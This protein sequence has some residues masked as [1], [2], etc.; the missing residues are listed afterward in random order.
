VGGGPAGLCFALVAK[1]RDPGHKVTVFERNEA[2]STYGWGVTF[3]RDL[4]DKLYAC[5]PVS[6]GEIERA[7]FRWA[8]Q[9]VDIQDEQV[10]RADGEGYSIKRQRLLGIMADRAAGLGVRIEFGHEVMAPPQLPAA[11]LIVACDGANSRTRLAARR[12]PTD[13]HISSNKYVW[14]GTDKVF[15]SF[16]YTF[17]RTDSGWVWAYGYGVDA[18]SSTFIV[19][20]SPE[21]WAGLGLDVMPPDESLRLLEKLFARQLGGHQLAGQIGDNTD[22]RWLNFHTI[23]NRHWHDGKVVLAG[24]AAHT[25]HYSIG[26]GTKLAIE[27]VIA[28]AE[29]LEEH[30]TLEGALSSYEAQRRAALLPPQGEARCSARWFENISRYVD[31]EPHQ[32]S[33][34]LDGRRSPLLPHIPPRLYY[35]LLR[36]S[37]NITILRELRKRAAPR[38]KAIYS[39]RGPDRITGLSPTSKIRH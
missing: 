23:T 24:D 12:F 31:L 22:V 3:G 35:R 15:D 29:N 4:L 30:D 2:D 39:R 17:V 14:L 25:T 34:L 26:W 38:A 28:L 8:G 18:A 32:F 10:R 1:L 27:D 6:A 13:T 19:E 33:M 11:D 37:D 5:D 20:C 16:L 36:A 21:T 9:V 7:A